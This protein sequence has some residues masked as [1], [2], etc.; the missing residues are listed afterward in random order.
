MWAEVKRRSGSSTGRRR[1][2]ETTRKHGTTEPTTWERSRSVNG[3]QTRARERPAKGWAD[4]STEKR[5]LI[6]GNKTTRKAEAQRMH[7]LEPN[8]AV[9]S[10]DMLVLTFFPSA[11]HIPVN[12]VLVG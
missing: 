5:S 3:G 11:V 7:H 1:S 2:A 9:R 6:A 10:V 8:D 12:N 4:V